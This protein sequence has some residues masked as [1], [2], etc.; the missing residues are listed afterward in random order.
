M[1]Q[2]TV[3][4]NG[5]HVASA[6]S[7]QTDVHIHIHQE[8]VWTQLLKQFPSCPRDTGPSKAGINYE[9]LA[10]GV[11][12]LLLGVV[13]CA[14]G[15]CLYFGPWTEL[16]ASGCA[17]WAGSV[18]VAAGAG[19]IAHEKYQGRRSGSVSGL[20]ALAGIATAT[21]AVV[22]CVNSLIW[23]NDRFYIEIQSVCDHPHPVTTTIGYP[24]VPGRRYQTYDVIDWRKNECRSSM[25]MVMDLFLG[26]CALLLAVCILEVLVSLVSLRM[27]LQSLYSQSFQPLDKEGSEKKL[28]G[29]NLVPPSPFKEK[30]L[31]VSIL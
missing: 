13:S 29:E 7:P 17:F 8:S 12:Q 9:Q 25:Q 5:V 22:L 28:L 27:S 30:T 19:A 16:C 21:A 4:V 18:A 2:N 20:F 23:Q 11:T 31:A 24:W 1:T 10:V 15:V 3:T 26:F 14:L 6:L